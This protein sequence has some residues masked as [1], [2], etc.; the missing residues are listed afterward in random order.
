MNTTILGIDLGKNWFF[1]VGIDAHGQETLRNKFNRTG[2][3]SFIANHPAT[4]VAMESCASSQYWGRTFQKFGHQIKLIPPQFAVPYRR[5]QK[6]DYNDALAI[7]EA[8][9][10]STIK[11]VPLRSQTQID[12]QALH[13]ARELVVHDLVQLNNQIRGLLLEN[14][15]AIPQGRTALHQAL[16]ICLAP[17]TTSLS[18]LLRGLLNRLY[19]RLLR[20]EE[21]RTLFDRDVLA[22]AHAQ[23]ACQR[24]MG[25]PGIGA[26]IATALYA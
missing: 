18:P 4:V 11:T 9:S 12:I 7:A 25:I 2:I 23:P 17:E 5:A 26:L 16:P 3:E 14:G 10:R 8:A 19:E 6:N 20:L 13:R 1:V 21:E 22:I 15:I 24:L